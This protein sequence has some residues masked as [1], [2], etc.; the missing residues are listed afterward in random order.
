MEL[1][2]CVVVCVCVCVCVRVCMCVCVCECVC[3]CVHVCVC[4]CVYV[5]VCVCVRVCV[6]VCGVCVCVY[7]IRQQIY[8][9]TKYMH[10]SSQ[11]S[12]TPN[13]NPMFKR[14]D[15]FDCHQHSGGHGA[16][17]ENSASRTPPY[18]HGEV[19]VHRAPLLD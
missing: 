5:C 4:V 12:V 13:F 11:K 9:Y 15:S 3:V 18:T 14:T 8:S 1:T 2:T 19:S 16:Q 10:T 17:V 7:V 6:C